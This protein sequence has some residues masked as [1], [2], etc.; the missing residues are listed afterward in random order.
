VYENTPLFEGVQQQQNP[1]K[2]PG[3][4]FSDALLNSRFQIS[5]RGFLKLHFAQFESI[6]EFGAKHSEKLFAS[7][8]CMCVCERE[9]V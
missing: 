3:N 4:A 8:M 6:N 1:P 5:A 7:L 2:T 9:R